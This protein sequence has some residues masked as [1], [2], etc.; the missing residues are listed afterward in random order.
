[1]SHGSASSAVVGASTVAGVGSTGPASPARQRVARGARRSAA[2]FWVWLLVSAAQR[3]PRF[4]RAV[5]PAFVWC[6]WVFSP[7]LRKTTRAN[8]KWLLSPGAS[9]HARDAFGRQVIASF[10]DFVCEIGVGRDRP[11]PELLKQIECVEGVAAYRQVRASKRGAIIITAHLGSFETGVAGL[12]SMEPN[13]HVVF[14]RD[15]LAVFEELRSRLHSHLGVHEAPVEAG[16]DG[17]FRLRDALRSDHVVLMQADRVMPGQSGVRVPFLGG[18]MELPAGPVKLA[19]A[20]GSP[21]IPAFAIRQRDGRSRVV[22]GKPIEVRDSC[23]RDLAEHPA[24]LE[25]VTVL[26]TYIK[27]YPTQWLAVHPAW[28]EDAQSPAEGVQA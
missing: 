15:R 3:A 28:C 18:H 13:V 10:Y 27:M 11:W 5:K 17:W 1:M 26:E 4:A 8:A 25:V 14:Q 20:S 9:G 7:Y 6:A 2:D 12:R 21:I 23:E 16:L 24:M 19:M 22:I